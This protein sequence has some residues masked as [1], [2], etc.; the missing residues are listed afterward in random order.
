MT[1][2][3]WTEIRT[4]FHVARLGTV[5]AAAEALGV[6]HA[7]VIR[8]IDALE[9]QLGTK[10]FHRH[11]RGYTPTEAGQDL[12]QVGQT[13]EEQFAHLVNRIRGRG[14]EV[15]GQ[16][17]ITAVPGIAEL[18]VP[19]IGRFQRMHP[20]L[21]VHYSS[22]M[23]KFRLEYGEAHVAIRAGNRPE[24]PDNI[25]QP[26]VTYRFALYATKGYAEA[27]GL[28]KSPDDL[29]GHRFVGQD[30]EFSRAPYNRWLAARVAEEDMVFVS[31]QAPAASAAVRA[32]IGI[33]F[34]LADAHLHHDG[35][36]EVF[37]G[38]AIAEW[39]ATAWIVT[40]MDLHRTA[41]V[42]QFVAFIRQEAK[43]WM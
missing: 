17:V 33:G 1:L 24:E 29:S 40:H 11:A 43:E 23:R 39:E 36:I 32:G 22:D 25:V 8:H 27:N 26:L 10:L 6:H 15:S 21:R 31:S 28:P 35:L 34:L 20:A 42:Q 4:A 19:S 41:K 5:S 30:R 37:P 38:A 2:D 18:I 16:L 3:S 7:T 9:R 14:E 12:L 13:T